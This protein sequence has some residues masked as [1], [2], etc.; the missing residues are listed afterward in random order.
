MILTVSSA[1]SLL[2]EHHSRLVNFHIDSALILQIICNPLQLIGCPLIRRSALHSVPYNNRHID[3]RLESLKNILCVECT[4]M[5]S[6]H[7][8]ARIGINV[9]TGYLLPCV[10]LKRMPSYALCIMMNL[11]K[12]F[13]T[14]NPKLCTLFFYP[15]VDSAGCNIFSLPKYQNKASLNEDLCSAW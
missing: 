10:L 14:F 12:L 6:F 8:H 5:K 11:F 2:F 3:I 13:T 15:K 1:I 7:L 4:I 9:W